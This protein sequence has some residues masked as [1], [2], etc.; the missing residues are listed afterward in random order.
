MTSGSLTPAS[1]GRRTAA[2]AIDSFV[3]SGLVLVLFYDALMALSAQ[4]SLATTPEEIERF[5]AAL[6]AFNRQSLP[7]IF[8]LFVLYHTVLIWQS[9]MTLGKYF[10]KIRVVDADTGGRVGLGRSSVRAL[11]RTAGELFLFYLPFVPAW[12]DP[13][14]RALHDRMAGTLVIVHDPEATA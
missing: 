6:R 3:M 2:F 1:L 12:F 5:L 8:A 9:G 4:M 13:M 11:V 10:V 14:H 7:Y